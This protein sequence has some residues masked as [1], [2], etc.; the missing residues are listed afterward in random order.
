MD[1]KD[2]IERSKLFQPGQSF[3]K[4][5][6]VQLLGEGGTSRIFKALQQPISRIVAL[7]IPSFEDGGNILTPDEFLSEATLMARLEHANIVRIYDFGVQE[8]KAFICMEYVEG[9]NLQELCAAHHPLSNSAVLSIA[10]QTLEG[11]LYSHSQDVLHLDLSPA[12]VL[13]SKTGV[14]KLSDFGMAGKQPLAGG[15]V[16]GTPAFLSPEHVAGAACTAQSDLFSFG[17]LLYFA[18]LGE[19]LFD[20]GEGN[21]NLAQAFAQI[22][23]ARA[24]PPLEKLRRLP[25]PMAALVRKALEGSDSEGLLSDLKALWTKA[26]GAARPEAVL[27]R[28]LAM[29]GAAAAGAV[30]GAG[31]ESDEALRARYL[32]LREDGLHREAVA[33]LEKALRKRPDH[34][35]LQELIAAPPAKVKSGPVTMEIGVPAAVAAAPRKPDARR[36]ALWASLA[37]ALLGTLAVTAARMKKEPPPRAPEKTFAAAAPARPAVAVPDIPSPPPPVEA[38]PEKAA[39][40]TKAAVASRPVR[41]RGPALGLA[42][43]AGTR[44]IVNDTLQFVSPSPGR[45]WNVPAGLTNLVIIRPDMKESLTSSLF[46]SPDTLYVIRLEEDGGF[47]VSRRR[48]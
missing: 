31:S 27:R 18:C 34:P 20:P 23:K 32:K 36:M 9:E 28:E 2:R 39:V 21:E 38:R 29:H 19:F 41:K 44:L 40:L 33:L 26:E 8:D 43:P 24:H 30:H 15:K 13:V 48:R 47:S 17:S 14:V 46:M 11:L 4:F 7:K 6:L 3:G 16:V 42:G 1:T 45:G 12:N 35:L 5:Y 10:C 25:A 22:E 37:A